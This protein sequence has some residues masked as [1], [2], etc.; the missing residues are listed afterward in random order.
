M[1]Y[2]ARTGGRSGAG[3]SRY[4]LQ[5]EHLFAKGMIEKQDWKFRLSGKEPVDPSVEKTEEVRRLVAEF[6]REGGRNFSA[7]SLSKYRECEV[8]FFYNSV[9]GIN[10]DPAP[11][12]YID[13]IRLGNILHDVMLNLYVPQKYQKK[14]LRTPIL[15]EH[16]SLKKIHDDTQFLWLLVTRAINKEH[17]HLPEEE[18]SRPLSGGAK[19][20]GR[21]VLEQVRRVIR[22]DLRLT[23]FK[24]LG[25]EIAETLRIPLS[26]GRVVNF[27]FAIDRLDEITGADGV[28][29]RRIVDYKTGSL[30]QDAPDFKSVF[31][32]DYKSE[33]LFQLLTYAWLL[34]KSSGADGN[35]DVM[36]EIYHVPGMVGNYK[37][38]LPKIGEEKVET[39][40]AYSSEFSK[41]MENMLEGVF[42][43]ERFEATADETR[44]E[45]CELRGLC[46][47]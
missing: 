42:S 4:I 13:A 12:E 37:T 18:L 38:E 46:R 3:V 10:T 21:Q 47:R 43:K 29:R 41:G 8:R 33:Q 32:G 26:S 34:G 28:N 30:K 45:L 14:F 20:V 23:P 25:G 9:L 39:Y 11:S 31:Y 6:E 1:I 7:S 15:I 19:M 24:I 22:R 35:D 17:F 40:A 16:D 27:S 2:D 5:L 36:V 44:C